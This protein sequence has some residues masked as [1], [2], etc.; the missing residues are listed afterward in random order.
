MSWATD[1]KHCL[2]RYK[3]LVAFFKRADRIRASASGTEEHF[4]EKD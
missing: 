3:L 4:G 2:D 1:G